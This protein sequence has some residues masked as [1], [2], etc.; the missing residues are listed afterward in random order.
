MTSF[1]S[2]VTHSRNPDT[3]SAI[4]IGNILTV[5]SIKFNNIGRYTEYDYYN[6]D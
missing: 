3:I 5:V 1:E 6:S 2:S 4:D